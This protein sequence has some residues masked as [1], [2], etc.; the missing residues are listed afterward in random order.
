M[1]PASLLLKVAMNPK[2]QK[3]A[4]NAAMQA[5]QAALAGG[6][7][8]VKSIDAAQ[9]NRGR[10]RPMPLRAPRPGV[11]FKQPAAQSQALGPR[12]SGSSGR[13]TA[14][15]EFLGDV[16][17]SSSS[18]PA[19]VVYELNPGVV[20]TFPRL[21]KE[22]EVWEEYR[23]KRLSVHYT[24]AVSTA[25][26]GTISLTPEYNA[27]AAP[28][29]TEA[30]LL[31][32]Q[33]AISG[34]PWAPL[35]MV[36]NQTA[37]HGNAGRKFVRK[38]PVAGDRNNYDVGKLIVGA[39]S[40]GGTG[41]MGKLW[42]EYEVEFFVPQVEPAN[43]ISNLVYVINRSGDQ[44]ITTGTI[45]AISWNEAVANVFGVADS[46]AV[47][48]PAGAWLIFFECSCSD[49]A[50]ETFSGAAEIYLN[51]ASLSP[52]RITTGDGGGHAGQNLQLQ[53]TAYVV[54]DGTDNI[55][56][57]ITLG[58]AAGTLKVIGDTARLTCLL[59]SA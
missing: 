50:V 41:V 28:P 38:N 35:N 16:L 20:A 55:K 49:T 46:S 56:A 19:T 47:V 11:V 8:L 42:L 40:N 52:P 54:T 59:I 25:T 1:D 44:A 21:S 30:G 2:I 31:N 5:A 32:H 3:Q 22:A 12:F 7:G 39:V 9:R 15:R 4:R 13:V 43:P 6:Q 24:P 53:I 57:V 14:G 37:M 27:S 33:G 26:A 18:T 34:N 45:T 48:L 23:F 17:G 29:T 58:G 51:N 10:R 36:F